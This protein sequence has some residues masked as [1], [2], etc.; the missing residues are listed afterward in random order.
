MG[1]GRGKILA[2]VLDKLLGRILGQ[3]M[4]QGRGNI[5]DKLWGR[6]LGQGVGQGM[7]QGMSLISRLMEQELFVTVYVYLSDV[8]DCTIYGSIAALVKPGDNWV[9]FA[10]LKC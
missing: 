7:G 5:L 9:M 1:Q 3:G 10:T 4:G 8:A 2:K 6:L